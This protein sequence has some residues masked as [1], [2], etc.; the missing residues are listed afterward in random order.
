MMVSNSN[1]FIK[2]FLAFI[3]ILNVQ[4]SHAQE[5][6]EGMTWDSYMDNNGGGDISQSV[7]GG[8]R[9]EDILEK[10]YEYHYA[11]FGK[12]DPF[13]PPML[14]SSDAE[15]A[16]LE[17]PIV[18]V[19]QEYP[20]ADLK[21]V[22]QWELQN[23]ERKAF[24]M[25]PKGEGVITIVGDVIG[26]K[27]G[28]VLSIENKFVTIREF[29]LAPDGTREFSDVKIAMGDNEKKGEDKII[30]QSGDPDA[31]GYK[32]EDLLPAGLLEND[33]DIVARKE[34]AMMK[35]DGNIAKNANVIQENA[36][37]RGEAEKM[38][39]NIEQAKPIVKDQ[40]VNN[41]M[42]ANKLVPQNKPPLQPRE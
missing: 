10:P 33:P 42:P 14:T 37:R 31:E 13:I 20:V 26:Q 23:G 40:G 34:K 12:S 30:M 2:L 9:V 1:L 19:L 28:K 8:I 22:G 21:M 38:Q 32:P 15:G 18:S 27:G 7:T 17:I 24:I 25:T 39:K 3:F 11:S 35:K 5:N 41:Q 29:T 16:R 36:D 4:S 6:D